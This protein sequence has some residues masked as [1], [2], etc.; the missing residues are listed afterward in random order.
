MKNTRINKIIANLL[1]AI[2]LTTG[3]STLTL[4][5]PAE[6]SNPETNIETNAALFTVGS[7]RTVRHRSYFRAGERVDIV[8]NGDGYTNLDLY[9]Y[10][11]Y[12]NLV[13]YRTGGSD[14][15]TMTLDIYRSETFSIKV[16]NRGNTYNQ[17]S[18]NVY[19]Y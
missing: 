16:V 10:D 4:A 18:L 15:E 17:Y 3:L 1:L 2:I 13:D 9:V 12:G 11:A 5:N 8:L 19:R 6:T 14:Y 7:Y